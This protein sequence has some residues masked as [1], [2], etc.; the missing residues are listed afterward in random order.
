MR[1]IWAHENKTVSGKSSHT[2][3]EVEIRVKSEAEIR[4]GKS[5]T[6]ISD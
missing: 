4:Q 3:N 5:H 1:E 2:L 6:G